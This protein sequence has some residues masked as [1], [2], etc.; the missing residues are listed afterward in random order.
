ME[1]LKNGNCALETEAIKVYCN[2]FQSSSSLPIRFSFCICCAIYTFVSCFERLFLFHSVWWRFPR[3]ELWLIS[4][5]SFFTIYVV[6][7]ARSFRFYRLCYTVRSCV[8]QA[9]WY[10]IVYIAFSLTQTCQTPRGKKCETLNQEV[11]KEMGKKSW[12]VR[13]FLVEQ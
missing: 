12:D 9:Q 10:T 11:E 3:F 1:S 2:P 8:L 5:H 6:P 13:N 7:T 4:W